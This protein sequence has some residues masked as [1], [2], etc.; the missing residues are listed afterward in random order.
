M[1]TTTKWTLHRKVAN[2]DGRMDDRNMADRNWVNYCV[3]VDGLH[4]GG[5][6]YVGYNQ[7]EGRFADSND[8]LA[9]KKFC[10]GQDVMR[11]IREDAAKR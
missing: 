3:R 2:Q 1:K 6:M 8:M 11:A 7:K 9:L 10:R 5:A 4:G